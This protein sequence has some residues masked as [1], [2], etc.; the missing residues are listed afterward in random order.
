MLSYNDAEYIIE[1][2]PEKVDITLI[3]TKANLYLAK[4]LPTQ[5]VSV[6]LNGLKPGVH[7]VKLRI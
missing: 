5:N 1:G 6:D 2:L 4:Q 7:K 3:G